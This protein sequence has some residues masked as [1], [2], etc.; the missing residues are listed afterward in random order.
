MQPSNK[1]DYL[2][3]HVAAVLARQ[4]DQV[5]QEQIGIGFSQFKILMVLKKSPQIQQKSIAQALGQ[6]EASVSR[7]IK[8]M[9]E[10]GLLTTRIRPD[11]RRVHLTTL[12][13]RG[14][15]FTD[16]AI[17]V[18]DRYHKPVFDRLTSKQQSQLIEILN[19]MH[20]EACR[21]GKSTS[22]QHLFID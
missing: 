4:N 14:E 2:L 19:L 8:L 12:T 13:S 17:R 22:D 20:D 6:T 1:I 5:L 7:Q 3:Q 9:I 15:R 21:P 16:E 18:L 10:Q 11:N